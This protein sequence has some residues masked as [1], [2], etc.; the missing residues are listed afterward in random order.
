V[1]SRGSFRSPIADLGPALGGRPVVM[2]HQVMPIPANSD[3]GS[4]SELA[5]HLLQSPPLGAP[6][7]EARRE[8]CK[9]DGQRPNPGCKCCTPQG[10]DDT[11]ADSERGTHDQRYPLPEQGRDEPSCLKEGRHDQE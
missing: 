3:F 5:L 6:S 1:L 9:G 8:N 10:G 2:N 4:L 11:E 7:Q